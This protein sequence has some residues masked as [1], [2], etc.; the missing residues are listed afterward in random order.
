MASCLCGEIFLV[1]AMGRQGIP[2]QFSLQAALCPSR[3]KPELRTCGRSILVFTQL[4]PQPSR[5]SGF[6]RNKQRLLPLVTR[7]FLLALLQV[8]IPEVF[9]YGRRIGSQFERLEEVFFRRI[10]PPEFEMGPSQA[11]EEG[12]ILWRRRHCPVNHLESLGKAL[13]LLDQKVPQVV[14]DD[15]IVAAS[16]EN[17]AFLDS[18]DRK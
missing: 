15:R 1:A 10:K 7:H 13:I 12:G 11:V 3:L 4:L 9:K 2:G 14:E 18:L 16:P 8:H 5:L 17:A 6:M